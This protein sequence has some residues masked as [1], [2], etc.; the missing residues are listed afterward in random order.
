MALIRMPKGPYEFASA[1]VKPMMP[2]SLSVLER[3]VVSRGVA[4]RTMLGSCIGSMVLVVWCHNSKHTS[5]V[6]DP[7]TA[8]P[9]SQIPMRGFSSSTIS[10]HYILVPRRT[11]DL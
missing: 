3:T 2:S 6:D 5:H 4:Q 11:L 9:R 1:L 8:N 7:S 10:I